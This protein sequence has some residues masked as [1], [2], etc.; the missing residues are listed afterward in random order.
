MRSLFL[1][2]MIPDDNFGMGLKKSKSVREPW[3]ER[4]GVVLAHVLVGRAPRR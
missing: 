2:V 1:Y 3:V 4:G